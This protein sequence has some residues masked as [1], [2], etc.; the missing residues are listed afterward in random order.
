MVVQLVEQLRFKDGR[1]VDYRRACQA[2]GNHL[3]E[4]KDFTILR[5]ILDQ[6]DP[7]LRHPSETPGELIRSVSRAL[8]DLQ[9]IL[10]SFVNL[11]PMF[12]PIQ[13][14]CCT[15]I[16]NAWPGVIECVKRLVPG[17]TTVCAQVLDATKAAFRNPPH[18]SNQIL[19]SPASMDLMCTILCHRYSRVDVPDPEEEMQILETL[20]SLL[21]KPGFCG[22]PSCALAIYLSEGSHA[23]RRQVP[24]AIVSMVRNLKTSPV[25]HGR[26]VGDWI[27]DLARGVKSAIVVAGQLFNFSYL[28]RFFHQHDFLVEY[29]TALHTLIERAIAHGAPNPQFWDIAASATGAM[30]DV[31]IWNRSPRPVAAAAQ[32]AKGRLVL[33]ALQCLVHLDDYTL[34]SWQQLERSVSRF[35]FLFMSCPKVASIVDPTY[36]ESVKLVRRILAREEP[37]LDNMCRRFIISVYR[38]RGSIHDSIAKA[39]RNMCSNLKVSLPTLFALALPIADGLNLY[40]KGV[41]VP[42]KI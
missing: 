7:A 24:A 2:F 26:D 29:S 40:R 38:G 9:G 4:D 32:C 36:D 34:N 5:D 12:E 16:L 42:P 6:F 39:P 15:I 35:G 37:R 11:D 8:V 22:T 14:A 1:S 41:V 33:S 31:L 25:P 19:C 23:T 13:S 17:G 28:W 3:A 27:T 10:D 21:A 18:L 30:I 20:A